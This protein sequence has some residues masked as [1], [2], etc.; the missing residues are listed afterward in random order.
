MF[1]FTTAHPLTGEPLEV[2][3]L[4]RRPRRGR[5]D[6]FGQPMEPDEPEAVIVAE[7]LDRKGQVVDYE[8]IKC[9]LEAD[10]RRALSR[11]T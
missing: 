7:V 10:A 3:A 4:Y 9:S 6:E 1:W 8:L 2:E 5:R 11:E